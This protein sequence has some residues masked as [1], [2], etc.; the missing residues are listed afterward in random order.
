MGK[1]IEYLS[2]KD[3][4]IF[5]RLVEDRLEELKNYKAEDKEQMKEYVEMRFM[6]S[7]IEKIIKE[8]QKKY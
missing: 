7:K 1:Y 2:G 4:Q 6:L 8:I 3:Y 5:K